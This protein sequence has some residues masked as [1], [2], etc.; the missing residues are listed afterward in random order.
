MQHKSEG[1]CLGLF[2]KLLE[3]LPES[4][5]FIWWLDF[6]ETL[7]INSNRSFLK[8]NI[9]TQN[10]PK[11]YWFSTYMLRDDGENTEPLFLILKHDFLEE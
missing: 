5:K 6:N 8:S 10:D 9:L 1:E 3:I 7:V 2:Q 4:Q 11:T